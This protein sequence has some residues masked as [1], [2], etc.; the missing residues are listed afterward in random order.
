MPSGQIQQNLTS[1]PNTLNTPKDSV[2]VMNPEPEPEQEEEID[3]VGVDIEEIKITEIKV[4]EANVTEDS[5]DEVNKNLFKHTQTE[6]FLRDG[7][8]NILI[9]T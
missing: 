4:E 9:R 7:T 8:K 1:P 3:I 2:T 5:I 6:E